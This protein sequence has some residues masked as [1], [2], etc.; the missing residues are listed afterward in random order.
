MMCSAE[1]HPK[2]FLEYSV[3]KTRGFGIN[4]DLGSNLALSLNQLLMFH[5]MSALK[6]ILL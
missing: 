5:E 1:L 3:R 2:V 6:K 4:S